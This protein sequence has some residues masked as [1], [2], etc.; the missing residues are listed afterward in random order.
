MW[1]ADLFRIKIPWVSFT[2]LVIIILCGVKSRREGCLRRKETIE[3]L[4]MPNGTQPEMGQAP[5]TLTEASGGG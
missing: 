5:G 3:L 1:P 2:H 4:S